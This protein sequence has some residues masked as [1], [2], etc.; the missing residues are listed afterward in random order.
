MGGC[1]RA[2]G[3]PEALISLCWRGL[4]DRAASQGVCVSMCMCVP[5]CICMHVCVYAC[6]CAH[7]SVHVCIHVYMG[8]H[9]CVCVHVYQA[10]TGQN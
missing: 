9:A 8:V 7:T 5:V 1:G 3:K 2:D 4:E 10:E 6:I